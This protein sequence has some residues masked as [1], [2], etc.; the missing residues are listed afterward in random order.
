MKSRGHL[1]ARKGKEWVFIDTQEP[2]SKERECRA[3]GVKPSP[4]GHDPCIA[5]LPNVKYACCGHYSENGYVL[6]K[7]HFI[8]DVDRTKLCSDIVSNEYHEG[9][10]VVRGK[11]E[12]ILEFV[13]N[14]LKQLKHGSKTK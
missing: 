3:C 2:I 7:D 1:I 8:P 14:Y 5:N 13:S 10:L 9:A 6:F 4:D 11:T 12:D